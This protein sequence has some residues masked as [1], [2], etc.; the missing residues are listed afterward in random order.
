MTH[1]IT[2]LKDDANAITEHPNIEWIDSS[3]H[4]DACASIMAEFD[5]MAEN[6]VQLF[7]FENIE[8]AK[9]DGFN[10]VYAITTR[11]NGSCDYDGFVTND[12]NEAINKAIKLANEMQADL[13]KPYFDSDDVCR[14]GKPIADCVC[15]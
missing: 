13:L 15:C 10:E 12:R 9:V 11:R 8:E 6:Y 1:Y 7:A 4:N 14:N 3:Y 2:Q 5:D